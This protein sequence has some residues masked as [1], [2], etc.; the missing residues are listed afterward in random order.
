MQI[1]TWQKKVEQNVKKHT[2]KQKTDHLL[3]KAK[4]EWKAY[5]FH[6]LLHVIFITLIQ[7][8]ETMNDIFGLHSSRNEKQPI[9]LWIVLRETLKVRSLI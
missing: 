7:F 3:W 6:L 5:D 8:N 4:L 1:S 9:Y 2:H